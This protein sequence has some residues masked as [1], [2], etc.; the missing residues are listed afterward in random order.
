MQWL[1]SAQWGAHQAYQAKA[2]AREL[3][4][5]HGESSI[6]NLNQRKCPSSIIN[7]R[8][9]VNAWQQGIDRRYGD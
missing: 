4:A 8:T 3:W 5:Q 7:K 6:I 2:N 1:T 9:A